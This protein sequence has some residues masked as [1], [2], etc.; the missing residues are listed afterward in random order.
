MSET[1]PTGFLR[2]S[3]A[4]ALLAQGIWG[5]LT[6][7]TVRGRK[8][9]VNASR[10]QQCVSRSRSMLSDGLKQ[11]LARPDLSSRECLAQFLSS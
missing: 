4:V 5:G 11:K 8:K 6:R 1:I 7:P 10:L 9:Q 3:E 2:F